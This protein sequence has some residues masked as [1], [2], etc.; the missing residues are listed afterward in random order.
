MSATT[1]PMTFVRW[2]RRLRATRLD[3]YPRSSMTAW[4]R[5]E[6]FGAT[7]YL[8]FT[9]RDTVAIDTPAWAATSLMVTRPL[10]R[11]ILRQSRNR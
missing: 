10:A 11:L 6:V 7:P 5:E 1:I 9:T 8:P 2:L 4:T 3:S